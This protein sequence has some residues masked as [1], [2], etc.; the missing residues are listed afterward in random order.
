[1]LLAHIVCPHCVGKIRV[2][3]SWT[4]GLA[5]ELLLEHIKA[6]HPEV[7]HRATDFVHGPDDTSTTDW[8]E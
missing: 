6:E 3:Y 4:E 5:N 8:P 7:W 2:L 1:M